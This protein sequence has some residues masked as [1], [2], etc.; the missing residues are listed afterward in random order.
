MKKTRSTGRLFRKQRIRKKIFGTV[1]KPRLCIFRS[2]KHF[3]AQIIDDQNGKTLVSAS[4]LEK[5]HGQ[6][7]QNKANAQVLGKRLAE[8]A[9]AA[10]VEKVVFDRNGYLFHGCVKAFADAAREGGLKF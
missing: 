3:Y 5:S 8:K 6:G 1:E 2:L 7:G 10:Q 4:T 9:K